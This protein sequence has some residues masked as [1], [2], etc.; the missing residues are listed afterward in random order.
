V[1]EGHS[2][3]HWARALK[4]LVGKTLLAVQAP[5][6]WS[7]R[8]TA[9]SGR[10]LT[11]I[12]THGKHLLLHTSAELTVHC[13]AMIYGS[14]QFGRPGMKLRKPEKNVRLR[15]GT[16]DF[17]AVF[18]NG[19][20]VELLTAQELREHEKLNALGPDLLHADFDREEAWRRLQ[21]DGGRPLG[22]AL[23]DQQLVAG[24]GNIFKSEGLFA[25]SL[26]PRVPMILVDRDSL[27]RLWHVLIPM[28]SDSAKRSG[29]VVTLNSSLRRGGERYWV[30]QRT[31]RPC[32]R[33]GTAV[34]MIRQGQQRR[35]TYY[36]P[37]CQNGPGLRRL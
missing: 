21:R 3:L 32:Y 1:A 25:A 33:C 27:E 16:S 20:V 22:D 4:P 9:L 10:H 30:Y 14:W 11:E 37:S 12:G 13:H 26:D 28:M 5:Q 23:L 19:P 29:P 35:T 34:A 8:V 7:E 6:R 2:V 31:R 17:E 18:F 36:C 24:V 15:L